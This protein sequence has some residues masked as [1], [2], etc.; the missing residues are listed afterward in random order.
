MANRRMTNKEINEAFNGLIKQYEDF[1]QDVEKVQKDVKTTLT[2]SITNFETEKAEI[3]SFKESHKE[4]VIAFKQEQEEK[5]KGI[6]ESITKHKEKL[7]GYYIKLFGEENSVEGL[8]NE[9]KSEIEDYHSKLLKGVDGSDSIQD[10]ISSVHKEILNYKKELFGY[11]EK[12]EDEKI[13]EYAGIK[14][15]I[16]ELVEKFENNIE[17]FNKDTEGLIE[18]K[19]E[20]MNILLD[21]M[22]LN[23]NAVEQEALSKKFFELSSDK[24]KSIIYSTLLLST[25]SILLTGALMILFTSE[26]LQD[27]F[28]ESNII[29]AAIIRIAITVPIMYL[30]FSTA[31]KLKREISIRDHYNF[32][33]SILSS[34]RN[35]STHIKNESISIS[36]F[37][38]TELL[39]KVFNIVLEN[40]ADKLEKSSQSGIK[41]FTKFI[42][43]LAKDLGTDK[44]TLISVLPEIIEKLNTKKSNQQKKELSS[45]DENK[46]E[47]EK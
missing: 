21:K 24:R 13:I 31:G 45:V 32:K 19:T 40:E 14:D 38:Q 9:L 25:Y 35:I 30:I 2:T 41:Y 26:T 36:E 43:D 1:K 17:T 22:D 15:E 34:Y 46:K 27:L 42:G 6:I 5:L 18:T 33:G 12:G 44:N 47:N 11:K 8:I 4:E 29:A 28:K 39:E 20:E 10:K 23:Y 7:D 37:K 3:K 16:D